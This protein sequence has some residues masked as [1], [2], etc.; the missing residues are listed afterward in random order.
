MKVLAMLRQSKIPPQASLQNVN[1]K[2][3]DLEPFKMA[4]PSGA[5]QPWDAPD[6]IRRAMVNSYGAAGSNACVVVCQSPTAGPRSAWWLLDKKK[7]KESAAVTHWPL[8]V[9]AAAQ[10]SLEANCR[11]LAKM[12][13]LEKPDVNKLLWTLSEKR[14]RHRF[15]VIL[16]VNNDVDSDSLAT[17]L[18]EAA[19]SPAQ[20][21]PKKKPVVFAFGG[22]SQRTIHLDRHLYATTPQLRRHLAECDAILTDLGYP[23]VTDEVL[24]HEKADQ[25]ILLLQTATFAVQYSC[26]RT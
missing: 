15:R 24:N 11:V 21:T 4:I 10:A 5:V 23:P 18:D 3:G 12:I 7:E 14:Q 8:I 1:P 17:A 25:G 26:A 19:S 9:S 22:Q 20:A 2:I 6:N 16:Q 13:R